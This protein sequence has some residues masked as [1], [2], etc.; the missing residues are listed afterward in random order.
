MIT[1]ESVREFMRE[2]LE[3]DR[4][5]QAV[6]VSG[7]T[8]EEALENASIELG[9]PVKRLEYEIVE[10]GSKGML[11]VGRK[12]WVILAYPAS[13]KSALAASRS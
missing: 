8:V 13:S 7:G 2:Q 11:G 5:T 3:A 4:N 6:K 9:I 12:D 10:Q 1:L